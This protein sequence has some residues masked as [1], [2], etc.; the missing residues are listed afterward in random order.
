MTRKKLILLKLVLIILFAL[1]INRFIRPKQDQQLSQTPKILTS[2]LNQ[3]TQAILPRTHLIKTLFVPQAPEKNWDQPWQDT[4]EEAA[5]LTTVYYQND[6]SPKLS[7]IKQDLLDI[8]NYENS[9]AWPKDI[10]L[11]QVSQIA[12]DY[13]NLKSNILV[14]PSLDDI[15]KYISQDQPVML[16]ANGKTLFRENKYF[17]DGG[18]FYHAL[19]ILGYND[20]KKQFTVHDVGTQHG[21]YFVYSYDTL[22]ESI[23]DLPKSGD[24]HDIN[25]GRKAIL[26]IS[27]V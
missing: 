25:D 23:H 20:T 2:P 13:F 1:L 17:K 6:Q 7:Q 8:I 9:Q 4:C 14:D 18:P 3:P 22:M 10:N 11:S 21:A 5:L 19:T 26:I 12:A 15:K 27:R 24:K 16:T